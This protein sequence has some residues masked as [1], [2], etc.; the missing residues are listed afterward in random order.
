VAPSVVQGSMR[1]V[2]IAEPW[3]SA[4]PASRA[5]VRTA[6]GSPPRRARLTRR[7]G[8][9]ETRRVTANAAT[10]PP[11]ADEGQRLGNLLL[12]VPRA[13]L[14]VPVFGLAFIV[15]IWGVA[16]AGWL[17]RTDLWLPLRAL[18][19]LAAFATWLVFF[20]NDLLLEIG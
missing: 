6:A 1:Q 17:L 14:R 9:G 7:R 2:P 18:L 3:S 4:K 12:V 20:V 19:A 13:A 10:A 16:L 8:R 15:V 5:T 11:P